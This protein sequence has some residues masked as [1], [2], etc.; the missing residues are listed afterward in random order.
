MRLILTNLDAPQEYVELEAKPGDILSRAI[1]LSGKFKPQSLCNGLGCCGNCRVRYPGNPPDINYKDQQIFTAAELAAG[2]RLACHQY[3]PPGDRIQLYLPGKNFTNQPEKIEN[4]SGTPVNACLAIDLGTTSIAWQACDNKGTLLE[5]SGPN[6][7]SGSGADVISRIDTVIRGDARPFILIRKYIR[8]LLFE[9]TSQGL[10][11]QR[12]CLAANPAMTQIFLGKDLSGLATAPYSLS[13]K[14]GEIL[15]LEFGE[16]SLPVLFPP[17]L[18]PFIGSDLTA[19]LYYCL[20]NRYPRPFV[21]ADLGTNTEIILFNEDNHLSGV[22]VPGGPALEGIGPICGRP[23]SDTVITSF[24]LSP[25]GLK[26]N[27]PGRPANEQ[28]E[29]IG[30]TGYLSLLAILLKLGILNRD[31]RIGSE[32][33]W[34]AKKF[35][36][37]S[38]QDNIKLPWGMCLAPDDIE[39]ILKVKAAFSTGLKEVL[40]FN[41]LVPGDI[42]AFCLA[43]N[44]GSNCQ[45]DDLFELGF[46]PPSLAG[47]IIHAGNTAL[48]GASLLAAKPDEL[49]SLKSLCAHAQIIS[50]TGESL[51]FDKYINEMCWDYQ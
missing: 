19:G 31:G 15:D 41:K 3:V 18:S 50:M 40:R 20:E 11:I 24:K 14:G 44:L 28:T 2:W 26:A 4:F 12:I 38:T 7:Q 43:G 22:S 33:P 13:F 5:G 42:R 17:L 48:K 8:D 37:D 39:Q 27:F 35:F 32:W 6:P 10:S 49:R 29:G 45:D 46:L 25:S 23:V 9:C 30:A 34:I 51:F 21:L 16:T 47:K 1:W 36:P